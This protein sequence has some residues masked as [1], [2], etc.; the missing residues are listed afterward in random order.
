MAKWDLLPVRGISP[1]KRH[2]ATGNGS[3]NIAGERLANGAEVGVGGVLAS[4]GKVAHAAT[5]GF[6]GI[7]HLLL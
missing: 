5:G 4:T 1:S 7:Q 2:L 3:A 6:E